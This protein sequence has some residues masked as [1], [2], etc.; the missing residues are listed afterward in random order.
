M[1]GECF[2][3]RAARSLSGAMQWRARLAVAVLACAGLASCRSPRGGDAIGERSLEPARPGTV[4][5]VAEPANPLLPDG[6]ETPDEVEVVPSTSPVT[7]L[8]SAPSA[9]AEGSVPPTAESTPEGAETR[10]I[11]AAGGSEPVPGNRSRAL[12]RRANRAKRH[13]QT[14]S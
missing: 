11:D 3:S 14:R 6:V 4:T 9:L 13:V 7:P 12:I 10:E 1:S 5:T 8:H 2:A